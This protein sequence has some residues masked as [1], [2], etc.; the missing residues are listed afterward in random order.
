MWIERRLQQ[1]LL[2]GLSVTEL[3]ARNSIY[4]ELNKRIQTALSTYAPYASIMVDAKEA[5]TMEDNKD[6]DCIDLYFK[7]TNDQSELEQ[8]LVLLMEYDNIPASLIQFHPLASYRTYET[9]LED[10]TKTQTA[11]R[12]FSWVID[13]AQKSIIISTNSRFNLLSAK[14]IR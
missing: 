2:G 3:R 8:A 9:Y 14:K 12:Y 4:R 6:K 10:K 11:R 13:F 1:P 7:K 5:F